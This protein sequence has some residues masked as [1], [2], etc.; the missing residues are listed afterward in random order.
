MAVLPD[1]TAQYQF[2]PHCTGHNV[3]RWWNA[4]LRLQVCTGFEIPPAIEAAMLD[5]TWAL[6]ANPT[7][8]LL[9]DPDP[10]DVST[11]Y[12]HSYRETMLAL[13][14]L[15]KYRSSERAHHQ[16]LKAVAQMQKASLDLTQWDLSL[17][18]PALAHLK[19]SGRGGEPTYTH[20]RAIEGLLCFHDATGEPKILEEA[21]RLAAFHFEHIINSDGSLAAGCGHHTH[22]YLNTI[23]GLLLY[24]HLSGQEERLA[25]IYTTYKNAISAMITRSGFV[26]HDIGARFGGDIASAGDIAHIA[27]L[28]WDHFKDPLLLEDAE[29]IVR[30][31]LL[32]AQVTQTMALG[33]MEVDARDCNQNL[34]GRFIGA[35][36]GSVGHAGGQTC[37]TDFTASALHCLIELYERTV[38][39]EDDCIRVNFH[40]DFAGSGV[41]INSVRSESEAHLT[42]LNE[43]AKS[44]Y[45]RIP[46]WAPKSSL[47]LTRDGREIY[48]ETSEGYA[49]VSTEGSPT[50]IELQYALPEF[51][52]E[53]PWR[54]EAAIQ[55]SITFKWRGDQIYE[56][57]P[58]GHYFKQFPKACRPFS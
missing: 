42:V 47:R 30:S 19:P 12:I 50:R 38:D 8:I 11:W 35:I 21:E 1:L 3:G 49:C 34:P 10:A 43:T 51:T 13:G 2:R 23:R 37:V 44:V 56:A 26:A 28:L 5:N 55:D 36:G 22:S 31:R 24:A 16:G 4:F 58:V 52:T 45:L 7:G 14:L 48:I 33:Q 53:E 46:S 18:D 39:I 20:G 9:E 40:F 32:P 54:D 27:L 15:V 25:A 41:R 57:D 29:K 17:C 6:S